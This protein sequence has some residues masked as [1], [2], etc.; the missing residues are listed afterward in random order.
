VTWYGELLDWLEEQHQHDRELR[1]AF[2]EGWRH[3][4][5]AAG[6]Q[7]PWL[8]RRDAVETAYHDGLAEGFQRGVA[9]AEQQSQREEAVA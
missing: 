6:L 2:R 4:Q 7:W 3:A 9:H 1:A 8:R 5:L